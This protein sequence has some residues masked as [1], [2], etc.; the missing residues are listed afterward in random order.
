MSLLAW[1]ADPD[2][3]T[4]YRSVG[5]D[6]VVS[7][8]DAPRPSAVPIEV[9]PPPTPLQEDVERANRAFEQ[10]LALIEVLEKSRAARARE[11]LELRSLELDYVR[12]TEEAE[13]AREAA[14]GYDDYDRYAYPYV[15]YY[16][17]Y[18]YLPDR[19]PGHRPGHRPE[20][21]DGDFSHPHGT[22]FILPPTTFR[23]PGSQPQQPRP[24][25]QPQQHVEFPH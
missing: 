25:R 21:H 10:Q 13:R 7:F 5:V 20:H 16:P 17:T 6:G 3:T 1:A 22:P 11:E 18:P 12:T 19:L 15:G 24:V 14:G 23:P 8:S 9:I 2:S 4:I